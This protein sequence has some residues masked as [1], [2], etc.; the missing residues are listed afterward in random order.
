M[1]SGNFLASGRVVTPE[2]GDAQPL[3]GE[4]LAQSAGARVLEHPP[5]LLLEHLRVGQA[6]PAGQLQQLLVRH[7]R[8]EEVRQPR[9]ERVIAQ[10]VD[11]VAVRLRLHQEQEVR[12]DQ[13]ALERQPQ[14]R[15]E[16]VAA[17]L[18]AVEHGQ[19][20][21]HFRVPHRP[22][23]RPSGE[24]RQV[25]P[26]R[27]ARRQ[28]GAGLGHEE[29]PCGPPAPPRTAPAPSRPPAPRPAPCRPPG[30]TFRR[31]STRRNSAL[32]SVSNPSPPEPSS[33]KSSPGCRSKP[34][35]SRTVLLYSAR[36][37]RRLMT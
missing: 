7:R 17:R 28:V 25:L 30:G 1:N 10:R 22:A 34:T 2:R 14:R 20:A 19:Q 3:A 32:P 18:A 13:H 24:R 36:L 31:G 33:G 11:A 9:G 37:S 5:D 23:E 4:V 26:G 35:R 29:P 12:R 21:V 16:R 27:L 8:P 15:L 6:V